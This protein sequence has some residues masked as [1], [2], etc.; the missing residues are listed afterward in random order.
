MRP[1]LNSQA[2]QLDDDETGKV[3]DEGLRLFC[4]L[5]DL[6]LLNYR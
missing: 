3:T 5:L 4:Y 6:V 1:C 2:Y